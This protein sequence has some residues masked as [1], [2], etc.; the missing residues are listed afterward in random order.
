MELSFLQAGQA[1][2]GLR[3][4]HH[5][6]LP[7]T[8]VDISV[9]GTHHGADVHEVAFSHGELPLL[10]AACMEKTFA[11]FILDRYILPIIL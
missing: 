4:A 2:S 9:A 6:S 10:L 5:T 8:V 7:Q 3:D 11:V 1:P